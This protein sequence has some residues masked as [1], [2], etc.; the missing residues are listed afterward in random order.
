MRY[1]FKLLRVFNSDIP[2]RLEVLYCLNVMKYFEHIPLTDRVISVLSDYA[3]GSNI[4]DIAIRH[5]LNPKKIRFILKKSCRMVYE[6]G[7][8]RTVG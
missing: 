8:K 4:E 2:I 1:V 7:N 6:F 5:Q 3:N